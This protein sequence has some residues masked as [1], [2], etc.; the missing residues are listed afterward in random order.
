[1]YPES[2]G[3][4]SPGPAEGRALSPQGPPEKSKDLVL[5][6]GHL[7]DSYNFSVSVQ[8]PRSPPRLVRPPSLTPFSP[9][10]VPRGD[11]LQG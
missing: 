11:W 2:I 1:M 6:L 3:V 5:H 9:H 4:P 10:A 7:N 8:S